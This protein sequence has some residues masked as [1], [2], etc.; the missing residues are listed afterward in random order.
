MI[1]TIGGHSVE[2][3]F[4]GSS[5]DCDETRWTLKFLSVRDAAL[6][7]VGDELKDDFLASVQTSPAMP[8]GR[9]RQVQPMPAHDFVVAA[10]TQ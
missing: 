9:R 4:G 5:L 3:T 10:L 1:D 7:S 2:E 6:F 8:P